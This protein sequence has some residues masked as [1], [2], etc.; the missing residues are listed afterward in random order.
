MTPYM[1]DFTKG[2][3]KFMLGDAVGGTLDPIAI[4]KD[5]TEKCKGAK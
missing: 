2:L 4:E 3:V 5:I 1:G